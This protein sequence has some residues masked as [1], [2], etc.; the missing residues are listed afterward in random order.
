LL[1]LGLRAWI[2][3]ATPD[4]FIELARANAGCT[5]VAHPRLARYRLPPSVR[6]E[7]DAIEVWNAAYDTR[8]LPDPRAVELFMLVRR[9]RSEVLAI[10]GL[11]Q[12]DAG[13]DRRTRV[14]LD[15]ATADPIAELRAGRFTNRGLTLRFPA[16]PAWGPV[17][18][19]ALRTLGHG[20]AGVERLH[21]AVQR[22]RRRRSQ[23]R[24]NGLAR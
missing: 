4:A 5:I 15:V 10:A 23:R 2:D 20:L 14:V 24:E 22:V 9:E 16:R 17:R 1:A 18:L 3:P 6:R 13:N 7:I 8:Y 21:N 12:H 11:D 19:A